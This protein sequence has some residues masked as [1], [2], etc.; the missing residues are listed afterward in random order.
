[1]QFHK[2]FDMER[3]IKIK[4]KPLLQA[5]LEDFWQVGI[6]MGLVVPKHSY[7]CAGIESKPKLILGIKALG[8]ELGISVS[9]VNR[10]I[11]QGTL[12]SA[13]YQSGK[14]VWFD[15]REVLN[16]MKKDKKSK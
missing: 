3:K 1:M 8:R 16:L 6:E 7:D 2:N 9:S 4:D 11:S 15:L 13:I 5:T 12:D 10:L 14:L